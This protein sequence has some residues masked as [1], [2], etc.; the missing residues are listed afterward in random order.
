MIKTLTIFFT[1]AAAVLS[2]FFNNDVYSRYES[3]PDV[4]E[5]YF[6]S[7]DADCHALA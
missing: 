2:S 4:V 6:G 1:T 7:A 5:A 3:L